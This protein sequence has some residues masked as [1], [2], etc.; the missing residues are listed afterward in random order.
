MN[1]RCCLTTNHFEFP[2]SRNLYLLLLQ[3]VRQPSNRMLVSMKEHTTLPRNWISGGR[4]FQKRNG[5]AKVRRA[6]SRHNLEGAD[7]RT[8][9]DGAGDVAEPL[10]PEKLLDH[11]RVA[12]FVQL[13]KPNSKTTI[14]K[15][16]PFKCVPILNELHEPPPSAARFPPIT[17][18]TLHEGGRSL[19]YGRQSNSA[20]FRKSIKNEATRNNHDLPDADRK[21]KAKRVCLRLRRR[22]TEEETNDLIKGVEIYG[23]GKWK[24]II[25]HDDFSFHQERTPVDLKD[26]WARWTRYKQQE[27]LN[28]WQVSY[29]ENER[30]QGFEQT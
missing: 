8:C 18:G 26:R 15:P 23:I 2:H 5:M 9:V 13:P 25:N 16:L 24:K 28:T 10:R 20:I 7:W 6:G 19:E 1:R 29:M 4:P 3:A 21:E 17:L 14:G 12:E 30:R 22:W 11:T 27:V